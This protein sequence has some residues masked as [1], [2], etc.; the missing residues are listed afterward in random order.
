MTIRQKVIEAPSAC[1]ISEA[2]PHS[3]Q[4]LGV[5]PHSR[6]RHLEQSDTGLIS[7][8]VTGVLIYCWRLF[9][10]RF[11]LD[12]NSAGE[13]IQYE[14][15]VWWYIPVIPAPG[16]VK[17]GGSLVTC[18]LGCIVRPPFGKANKKCEPF[19]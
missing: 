1:H 16:R 7:R 3:R 14:S 12:Y 5:A 19:M 18:R 8:S 9:V 11:Y 15:W 2:W 6:V 10:A 17:A 4:E 13:K